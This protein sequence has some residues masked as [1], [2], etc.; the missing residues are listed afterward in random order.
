MSELGPNARALLDAASGGDEPTTADRDRVRTAI[1]T[2]LAVGIAAGAAAATAVKSAGAAASAGVGGA[3]AAMS[4]ATTA[5]AVAAPLGLGTKVL[6]SLALVSAVGAGAA[7]YVDSTPR[8]P[9]PADVTMA[10]TTAATVRA[11]PPKA[12]EGMAK[13]STQAPAAT[14]AETAAPPIATAAPTVITTAATPAAAPTPTQTIAAPP[15]SSVGAELSLLRDAHAALQSG[16]AARAVVLL[17][18]HARR[19]PAGAL[20]EERDAARIFALCALGRAGEA[21]AAGDRFLAA[22]PRSPHGARVRSSC[23]G[24]QTSN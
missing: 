10:P 12:A 23:G 22:Y 1:G 5:A 19:F 7:S 4:G 9:V 17:D 13:P 21:R 14:T 24:A 2:R 8:R 15:A 3:T 16:D 18:E 6:L 20:G 11:A